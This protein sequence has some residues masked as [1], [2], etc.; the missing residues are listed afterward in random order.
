MSIDPHVHETG[1]FFSHS[2]TFPPIQVP[3]GGGPS[4]PIDVGSDATEMVTGW[5]FSLSFVEET[6]S[7]GPDIV[8]DLE[9]RY[10]ARGDS[11]YAIRDCSVSRWGLYFLPWPRIRIQFR[12]ISPFQHSSTTP[13]AGAQVITSFFPGNKNDLKSELYSCQHNVG[14]GQDVEIPAG[15][16]HYQ[17]AQATDLNQT[18]GHSL[19]V[20]TERRAGNSVA[21][22]QVDLRSP[23][24][25]STNRWIHLGAGINSS[26]MIQKLNGATEAP[27]AQANDDGAKADSSQSHSDPVTQ[28][29]DLT[30]FWRF[31]L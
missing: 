9:G 17:V 15:A 10:P 21:S 3:R 6:L 28:S 18:S 19:I 7:H 8:F 25:L 31:E 22:R 16:T 29:G 26:L 13:Q 24:Q 14:T 23:D 11:R 20:V 4:I 30:V 27:D 5:T 2:R 12:D 1:L